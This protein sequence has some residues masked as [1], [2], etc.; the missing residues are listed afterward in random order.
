[1]HGMTRGGGVH[2]VPNPRGRGWANEVC[3][4]LISCH[5]R[6][7]VAVRWGRRMA[8]VGKVEHTIH[9]RDGRIAAKNSYGSD[10]HPPMDGK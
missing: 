2:T 9:D 1:M 3:G 10:P 8:R 6:K 7:D 4:T 5:Q